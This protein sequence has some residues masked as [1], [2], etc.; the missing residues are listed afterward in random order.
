VTS[1]LYAADRDFR[2]LGIVVAPAANDLR[3]TLD[4]PED[5]A[6]IEAVV[7]RLGD[8]PPRWQEVVDLL[9][10]NPDVVATNASVQQKALTDG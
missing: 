3:V 7:D 9:R 10:A 8:A 1:Y 4:T 2:R 6:A 5:A